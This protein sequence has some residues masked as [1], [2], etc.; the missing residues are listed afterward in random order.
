MARGE[1]DSC[2]PAPALRNRAWIAAERASL[3]SSSG[4][5]RR[6]AVSLSA[7]SRALREVKKNFLLRE[8]LGLSFP[9]NVV[10]FKN[11]N[12]RDA[13]GMNEGKNI[14]IAILHQISRAVLHERNVSL[15]L[16]NVLDILYREMG[17]LRGTFTLRRD[18]ML[19]IEA[20]QG[21]S[22]DEIRRGKYHL[23]EGITGRVAETGMPVI[24][25]DISRDP[26]FLNRTKTRNSP[27]NIAFLC[28]PVLHLE[29]VIGTLSIDRTSPPGPE[30]E[31]SL[32][33][34]LKLLETVANITAEV[35]CARLEEHE[36]REKL[37]E[38]NRRLRDEL[39]KKSFPASIIGNCSSMRRVYS[40]IEQVADTNATV[41]IRGASGTGKELIA[42]A[43][44]E[45]SSRK[46]KPF[47]IVN[48]AA[49]PETLIESELFGHEKGSFTGAFARRIGRA[50]AADGGTLFLDEIGDL[51]LPVQVKLL[52]FL[53]ERT[54]FRVGG[55]EELKM[56]VRILAATSRDLEKLMAEGKFREDLYYRLNVFPIHLPELR[57]R[58]SDIMLLAEHF[59]EKFSRMYGKKIKRI[60]TPAINMMMSYHWPGNVRELENCI[61]RAV[62]TTT[63]DVISGYNLPPSLQT[64]EASSTNRTAPDGT[65]D[66]E[67]LVNSFER[68][69]I[70]E[71]LKA[72]RGNVSASARALGIS[73]RIIHYKI[74]KLNITPDWYR[75][76]KE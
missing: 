72:N 49:M 25:P 46:D 17:F 3:R 28:V 38:E 18:D 64:G 63:D 56:D 60:S 15:L 59:L 47:I 75:N 19:V 52:R 1:K 5:W 51:T 6:G 8:Y 55:N 14:E 50:E 2:D 22:E 27:E 24:I 69:L 36:E 70:V 43:I 13:E 73:N 53:Q 11:Q 48:C 41:L 68:E 34:D 29:K 37:L 62:L 61:E 23:G 9:K 65:A 33:E 39:D 35:V 12:E 76:N 54:F 32:K 16:K 42:R 4:A 7:R 26:N 66:F 58:R 45:K 57:N 30:A 71:S 40:M 74:Q 31:A 21:L 10:Y 67:T 20:S 44:Q